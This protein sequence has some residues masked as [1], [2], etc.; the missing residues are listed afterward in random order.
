[1]ILDNQQGSMEEVQRQLRNNDGS[2]LGTID[3]HL[4]FHKVCARWVIKTLT[5]E[6]KDKCLINFR[7]IFNGYLRSRK[8]LPQHQMEKS[9]KATNL[10]HTRENDTDMF[11][12]MKM[13]QI[14]KSERDRQLS[15]QRPF[16]T[17]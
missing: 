17:S 7:G 5:G 12:G 3:D 13:T 4:G 2:A 14:C 16:V 6:H 10:N 11:F 8:P 1:M 9:D 15:K